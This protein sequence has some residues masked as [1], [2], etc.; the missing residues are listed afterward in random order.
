MDSWTDGWIDGWMVGVCVHVCVCVCLSVNAHKNR[1]L[2]HVIALWRG[3]EPSGFPSST[4]ADRSFF[5]FFASVA[6]SL[7]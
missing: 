5:K 1:A 3:E 4:G 2:I 7:K 6:A